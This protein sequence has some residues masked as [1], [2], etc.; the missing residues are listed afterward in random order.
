MPYEDED[1]VR[2]APVGEDRRGYVPG[3]RYAAPEL[4][5]WARD[6]ERLTSPLHQFHAPIL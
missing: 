4:A 5:R 2:R 1:C 3:I 6:K